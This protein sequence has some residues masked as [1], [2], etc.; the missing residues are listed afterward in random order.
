MKTEREYPATFSNGENEKRYWGRYN[1]QK[2][3]T[4]AKVIFKSI[5]SD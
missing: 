5:I 1:P 3:Y 2:L 4:K